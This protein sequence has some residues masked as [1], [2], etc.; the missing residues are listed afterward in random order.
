ML[1]LHAPLSLQMIVR[2]EWQRI[3]TD[4]SCA[5]CFAARWRTKR[6]RDHRGNLIGRCP[7]HHPSIHSPVLVLWLRKMRLLLLDFDRTIAQKIPLDNSQLLRSGY[8]IGRSASL[9]CN[10]YFSSTVKASAKYF[11]GGSIMGANG[12]FLLAPV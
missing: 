12:N 9:S 8:S 11:F 7:F 10:T 6:K 4:A 5:W 1:V 2:L 3:N